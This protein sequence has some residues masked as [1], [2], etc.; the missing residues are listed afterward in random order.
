MEADIPKNKELHWSSLDVLMA[1]ISVETA[2]GV[3]NL[4]MERK[5]LRMT[6]EVETVL[7]MCRLKENE[8]SM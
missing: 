3:R 8:L 2:L 6:R 4:L 5:L 7:E 1:C